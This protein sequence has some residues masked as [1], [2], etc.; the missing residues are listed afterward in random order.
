MAGSTEDRGKSRRLGAK[1]RGWLST[2]RVLGDQ[3]I[4]RSGDTV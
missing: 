3:T 1:D 4:E 2:G